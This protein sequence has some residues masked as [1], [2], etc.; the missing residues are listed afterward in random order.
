[1][2]VPEDSLLKALYLVSGGDIFKEIGHQVPL[3]CC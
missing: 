2:V 1:M 3:M